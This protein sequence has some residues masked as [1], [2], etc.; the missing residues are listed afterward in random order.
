MLCEVESCK[1]SKYTTRN[2]NN[3]PIITFF[4]Q[5]LFNFLLCFHYPSIIYWFEQVIVCMVVLCDIVHIGS[6]IPRYKVFDSFF[7]CKVVLY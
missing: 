3:P 1:H 2:F 5:V 6:R 4:S 7:S